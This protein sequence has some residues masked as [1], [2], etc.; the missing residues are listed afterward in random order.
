M[1]RW[2]LQ[3]AA[4][5]A[6]RYSMDPTLG[7]RLGSLPNRL[8]KCCRVPLG[9]HVGV[10][11]SPSTGAASYSNLTTCGSVWACPVCS[12]KV[13]ERRRLDLTAGLSR[14]TAK[15]GRVWLMSLTFPHA[16]GDNLEELLAAFAK[17][18]KS[19]WGGR[20]AQDDAN[21]WKLSG[22]VTALEVTHGA[23]GWHP[24]AHILMF[25][26]PASQ[27]DM[28][29][30]KDRLADRW[31]KVCIKA[32]LLDAT[33]GD[34]LDA[35][36]KRG[37]DL[38][39]GERAASYVSKFGSEDARRGWDLACEVTKAHLKRG[40]GK[41]VTAWDLLRLYLEDGDLEP[42]ALFVEYVAA[43]KGKRQLRY[44]PGLRAELELQPEKTD[45]EE[46]QAPGQGVAHLASIP[47]NIWRLVVR[48]DL[49][50]SLL[51]AAA[52]GDAGDVWTFLENLRELRAPEMLP[53]RREVVLDDGA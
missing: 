23:N 5:D 14:W 15:G 21:A 31:R 46:A 35:F 22:H 7:D 43:F 19:F 36:A 3:S 4:T 27:A 6:L 32:G 26:D 11:H 37:L 40:K 44:S 29:L 41:S 1:E 9:Q 45:E 16:K 39:G 34:E 8:A 28:E 53:I 52:S 18:R 12:A 13:S 49:R 30:V 2:A 20:A 48:Y 24:H 17:A 33:D 38:R 42:A 50:G 47:L 25:L 10:K 51:L